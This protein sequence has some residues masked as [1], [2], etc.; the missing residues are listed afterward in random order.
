MQLTDRLGLDR[1]LR[2]RKGKLQSV[3]L[4]IC[5]ISI[6][7]FYLSIMVSLFG[8]LSLPTDA[9]NLAYSAVLAPR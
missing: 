7:V 6:V 5:T 9:E 2:S 1:Y 4:M 3:R 8:S